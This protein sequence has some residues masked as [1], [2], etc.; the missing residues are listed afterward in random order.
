MGSNQEKGNILDLIGNL[1]WYTLIPL[2]NS[3]VAVDFFGHEFNIW[4][5]QTDLFYNYYWNVTDYHVSLF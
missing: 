1:I 4:H 2:L 5:S 3:K